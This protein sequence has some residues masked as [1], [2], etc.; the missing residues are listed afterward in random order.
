M[1]DFTPT[2][3]LLFLGSVGGGT[4]TPLTGYFNSVTSSPV[5]DA[6]NDG[7]I[8]IGE[9]LTGAATYTGYTININGSNYAIFQD[10]GDPNQFHIPYHSGADDLSVLAFSAVTHTITNTG[11][12]AVV[13]NCF[14]RN[15]QITT[16]SGSRSVENLLVGDLVTTVGG[17]EVAVKWVRRHTV[18][19]LFS[20]V[21]AQP[22]RIRAGAL[23]KGLPNA[24]LTVSADH[25]MIVD[26]FVINAS[27]LVNGASI[28]FVPLDELP[29]QFTYYHIETENHE[30]IMANG[31][32]AETFVDYIGRQAFDNYGEYV[33]RYGAERIIPEMDRP[34]IT[35]ARLVP[36]TIKSRLGIR[37]AE[38]DGDA[39]LSA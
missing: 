10:N 5:S 11:D 13:V 9:E 37:G 35:S 28:D 31:A 19:P 21:H 3:S 17:N 6:N 39:L 34:R 20:G 12:N 4:I 27:A 24:D 38:T 25:G 7:N 33:E 18:H 23:G 26:G 30:V 2:N 32:P 1:P 15:T 16:P 8:D 14:A 29:S 36:N 22:I